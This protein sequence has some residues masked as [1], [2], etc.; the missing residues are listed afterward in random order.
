MD[1]I[2]LKFAGLKNNISKSLALLKTE[3]ISERKIE[4][5]L[6]DVSDPLYIVVDQDGMAIL[7]SGEDSNRLKIVLGPL[8]DHEVVLKTLEHFVR[9]HESSTSKRFSMQ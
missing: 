7:T 8:H 4:C 5:Y 6:N 9:L 2:N 3:L 1:K